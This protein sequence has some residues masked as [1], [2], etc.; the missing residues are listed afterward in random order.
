[1][2]RYETRPKPLNPVNTFFNVGVN[3]FLFLNRWCIYKLFQNTKVWWSTPTI[4]LKKEFE[5]VPLSFYNSVWSCYMRRKKNCFLSVYIGNNEREREREVE[6]ANVIIH[7]S[8]WLI[9]LELSVSQ[10]YT[11]IAWWVFLS[12][13][14]PL[15][16]QV[17]FLEVAG[18]DVEVDFILKT[19]P[20]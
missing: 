5:C 20:S 16:K 18:A 14:L 11:N 19:K 9:M 12:H 7:V 15:L 2:A 10:I 3:F 17:S 1:M 13:F 6:G 8:F 4:Q